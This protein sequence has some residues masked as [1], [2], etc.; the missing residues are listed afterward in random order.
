[1]LMTAPVRIIPTT[2]SERIAEMARDIWWAYYPPIIGEEQVKYMLERFYALPSLQQQMEAGQQFL[3]IEADDIAVGFFAYS[4]QSA[5]EY[6]IHKWYIST[7]FQGRG[8]GRQVFGLWRE[9]CGDVE[10]V[11]LQV[12]RGNQQAILFYERLGFEREREVK[13]D[14][15]GGF[16]MDDYMMRYAMSMG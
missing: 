16:F 1:M 5:G 9:M 6:F 15:G 12:N 13:V 10:G 7:A 8:I 14:I 3:R 11:R 2:D 4:R